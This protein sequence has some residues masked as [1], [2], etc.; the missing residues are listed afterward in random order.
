MIKLTLFF[1]LIPAIT[2]VTYAQDQA[3]LFVCDSM[4]YRMCFK[5]PYDQNSQVIS[6]KDLVTDIKRVLRG[7]NSKI[8]NLTNFYLVNGRIDFATD[9][10]RNNFYFGL[11]SLLID[12]DIG[13]LQRDDLE[14]YIFVWCSKEMVT[15]ID[16]VLA[17][18]ESKD[19]KKIVQKVRKKLQ[20][21]LKKRGY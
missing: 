9:K 6:S 2:F 19:E 1:I 10:A 14:D 18:T 5:K 4:K 16:A 15:Q 21:Q 13:L 8:E 11:I 20:K 17:K 3:N 12:P 7:R